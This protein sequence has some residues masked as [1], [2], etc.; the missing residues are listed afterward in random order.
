MAAHKN[1]RCAGRCAAFPRRTLSDRV[2][3]R[4]CVTDDYAKY[5]A[6]S[7]I[8]ARIRFSVC[9]CLAEGTNLY[10]QVLV[11]LGREQEAKE[12]IAEDARQPSRRTTLRG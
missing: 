4:R 2:A 10:D 6:N 11:A 8:A 5:L 12:A 1:V 3:R 9:A 7:Q